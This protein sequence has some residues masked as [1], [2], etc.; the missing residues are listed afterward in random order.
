M[1]RASRSS[2]RRRR[3]RRRGGGRVP[4]HPRSRAGRRATSGS[5]GARPARRGRSPAPPGRARR[6]RGGGRTGPRTVRFEEAIGEHR[7]S[8]GLAR[9][10]AAILAMGQAGPARHPPRGHVLSAGRAGHGCLP[11]GA[12]AAP[13]PAAPVAAEPGEGSLDDPTAGGAVPSR[14]GSAR[15]A[16]RAPG[17][18]RRGPGCRPSAPRRAAAGRACRSAGGA[19]AS[20]H[21]C[22]RPS[23]PG[24]RVTPLDAD[25]LPVANRRSTIWL[26]GRSTEIAWRR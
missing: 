24:P 26:Q 17:R 5:R 22:L 12:S 25:P 2:H 7:V 14:A 19:C 23:P 20:S 11:A 21:A 10:A 13:A 16:R 8:L 3:R 18:L 6:W 4:P 15:A 9:P 1:R